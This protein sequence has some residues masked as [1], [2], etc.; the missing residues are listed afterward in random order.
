MQQ[1]YDDLVIYKKS[2]EAQI[3]ALAKEPSICTHKETEEMDDSGIIICA[4]HRCRRVISSSKYDHV[5]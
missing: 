1:Y 2:I 3:D 4:N 5:T